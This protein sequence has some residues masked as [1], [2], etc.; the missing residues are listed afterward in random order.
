MKKFSLGFLIGTPLLIL[1]I[2]AFYFQNDPGKISPAEMRALVSGV[3][4]LELSIWQQL[5]KEAAADDPIAWNN[6][7]VALWRSR[8]ENS[9]P[10]A[11]ALFERAAKAGVSAARYNL[12]L[13]LPDKFKT[14]PEIIQKHL[15]LLQEN[16]ALG[17]IHSMV[18]LSEALY[19]ANRDAYVKDRQGLKLTLLKTA[20]ASGDTD[21][22]YIYANELWKQVRGTADPALLLDVIPAFL[23]VDAADDPRG[24]EALA[25]ILNSGNPKYEAPIAQSGLTGDTV[26]WYARA[27]DL[28]S[29]TARCQYG[30]NLFRPHRF[31]ELGDRSFPMIMAHFAS[32]KIVH[33]TPPEVLERAISDLKRCAKATKLRRRPH[34]PFGDPALYAYKRQGPRPSL[35]NSVGYAN[36]NLGILYGFG[37]I[38]P[39]DRDLAIGYLTEAA[40]KHKF[41]AAKSILKILPDF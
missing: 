9:K 12:A 40:E 37:I 17:D 33:G 14:N 18:R 21:Y 2:A 39:Q 1:S 7:G 5:A 6:Y 10:R 27:G 24:A 35:A 20:A 31:L 29:I 32:A 26:S 15:G 30:N 4:P 22:I 34:R 38:V 23:Q 16:V 13:M 3:Q 11:K 28:G 8:T 36:L 41:A 19:F 25:A